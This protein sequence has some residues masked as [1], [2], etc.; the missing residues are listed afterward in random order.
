MPNRFLRH[1][2]ASALQLACL[3]TVVASCSQRPLS[4]G[5]TSP[6][7][8]AAD[9]RLR[10]Y[11]I[12][13]DS[14]KG[15]EAGGIGNFKMTNLVE[16]EMKRLGLEPGGENGT[17]FQTIPMIRRYVDS[18]ST[19]SVDGRQL[20]IYSEFAVVRPSQSLRSGTSL[21]ATSLPVVYGGRAGD[22]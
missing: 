2:A 15:R 22:S 3:V 11:T 6:E 17:Y 12:A 8:N 13:D 18:S 20:A 14:M 1:A 7:I 9:T 16:R 4:P 10:V 19:F 21:K 5:R